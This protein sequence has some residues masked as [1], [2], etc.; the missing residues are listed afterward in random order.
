MIVLNNV[1]FLGK[2]WAVSG[3]IRGRGGLLV[4]YSSVVQ[5]RMDDALLRYAVMGRH[6]T[7]T[8]WHNTGNIIMFSC[9]VVMTA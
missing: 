1:C 8:G 2:F 3:S 6:V 5:N 4:R 7:I 9:S